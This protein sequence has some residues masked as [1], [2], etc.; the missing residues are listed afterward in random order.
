MAFSLLSTA[1]MLLILIR[2]GLLCSAVTGC[3]SDALYAPLTTDFSAWYSGVTI[4]SVG[5]L[6]LVA[7]Y[8]FYAALAGRSLFREGFLENWRDGWCEKL[9]PVDFG[10]RGGAAGCVCLGGRDRADDLR[11]E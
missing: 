7:G 6:L 8:G 9:R 1:L 11:G 3:I 2:F 4:L 10:R 5:F